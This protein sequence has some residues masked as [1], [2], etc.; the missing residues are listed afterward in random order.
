VLT[1]KLEE[2]SIKGEVEVFAG[3]LRRTVMRR[4]EGFVRRLV[5]LLRRGGEI[6]GLFWI[7]PE[8]SVQC[9]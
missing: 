2:Q 5:F 1:W 7:G 6:S 4:M 8:C 3:P 9:R